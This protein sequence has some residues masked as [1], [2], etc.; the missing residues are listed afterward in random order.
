MPHSSKSLVVVL[1]TLGAPAESM[2]AVQSLHMLLVPLGVGCFLASP[3][4]SLWNSER[5]R[6]RRHLLQIFSPL[7]SART[8]LMNNVLTK[9]P[10]SLADLREIMA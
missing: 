4:S 2:A 9:M 3:G 8:F 7:I 10:E 5:G 6:G 1:I